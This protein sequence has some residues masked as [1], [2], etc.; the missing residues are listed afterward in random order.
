[1]KVQ[2]RV[3]KLQHRWQAFLLDIGKIEIGLLYNFV[4]DVGNALGKMMVSK[5]DKNAKYMGDD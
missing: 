1:M 2:Y 4:A 5:I 3:P